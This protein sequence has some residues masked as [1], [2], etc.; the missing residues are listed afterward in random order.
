MLNV[1]HYT[2][3]NLLAEIVRRGKILV[4]KNGDPLPAVWLST[5]PEWERGG[6]LMARKIFPVEPFVRLPMKKAIQMINTKE[7]RPYSANEMLSMGIIPARIKINTNKAKVISCDEYLA[8]ADRIANTNPIE[9]E[10]GVAE[11]GRKGNR[12]YIDIRRKLDKHGVWRKRFGDT[13]QW[14]VSLSDIPMTAFE[15]PLEIWNGESWADVTS[16]ENLLQGSNEI[17]PPRYATDID[18]EQLLSADDTSAGCF[19]GYPKTGRNEPCPCGSGRKYKKC[20]LRKADTSYGRIFQFAQ[21][22]FKLPGGSVHGPAHWLRVMKNGLEIADETYADREIVRLFALLHDVCRLRDH[23]D[24]EHGERAAQLV[25]ELN[26]SYFSLSPERLDL[27][28]IACRDHS[29]GLKTED[30]TIAACWDADRLDLWRVG[31]QVDPEKLCTD[32]ARW[33]VK[34]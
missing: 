4:V 6:N 17:K 26:N 12:A 8:E 5:N 31:L 19:G 23:K 14:Y 22:E 28:H 13:R 7:F 27:L 11:T 30:P 34:E 21:R 29:K 3:F 2:G 1:W 24:P 18:A 20:C 32:A 10:G 16:L 9:P 25:L 33:I 15:F